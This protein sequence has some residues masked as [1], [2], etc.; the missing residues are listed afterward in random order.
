MPRATTVKTKTQANDLDKTIGV[1]LRHLRELN[2]VTQQKL[3]EF[4]NISFQQL[5]KY[6]MGRNRI[7]GIRLFEI[8]DFFQVSI[9]YFAPEKYKDPSTRQFQ[10]YM[11]RIEH[12]ENSLEEIQAEAQGALKK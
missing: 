1:R 2:K 12:L 11:K 4:L 10:K 9:V 8:A 6:E 3:A 5:Q 7:S